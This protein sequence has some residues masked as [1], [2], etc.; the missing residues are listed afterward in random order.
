MGSDLEPE[1]GPERSV[2]PVQR[3]IASTE[4]ARDA[5]GF[6][7]DISLEEGLSRLVDWWRAEQDAPAVEP[8]Q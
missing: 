4:A 1:Y 8:Q 2:N 5:L 7:T 6:E 3:R